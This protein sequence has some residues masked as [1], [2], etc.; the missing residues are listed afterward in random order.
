[1]TYPEW[2]GTDKAGGR[3]IVKAIS[4]K[5]EC[6]TKEEVQLGKSKI[7]IRKPETYFAIELLRDNA[8]GDFVAKIQRAWRSFNNTKVFVMMQNAMAKLYSEEMKF[9]RRDSIF[10]PYQGDYLDS[11]GTNDSDREAIRE[12]LYRVIDYY[13]D[14]EN[15]V[16]AEA[17]INENEGSA[18]VEIYLCVFVFK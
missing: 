4:A 9:R 16:F 18:C 6:I 8:L 2:K 3:E 17:G 7:F 10:R 12:S 13:D 11:I 15:I 1:M 5:L 14:T